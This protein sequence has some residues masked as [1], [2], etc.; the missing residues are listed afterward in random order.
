MTEVSSTCLSEKIIMFFFH[1]QSAK[2]SQC[3][4]CSIKIIKYN[5]KYIFFLNVKGVD[6]VRIHVIGGFL[7][8]R[9]VAEWGIL[10]GQNSALWPVI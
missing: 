10:Q 2:K 8:Q 5:I 1:I 3:F 4:K 7:L 6:S 9:G